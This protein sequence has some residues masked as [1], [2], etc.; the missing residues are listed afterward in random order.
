MGFCDKF[1]TL[2]TF[3]EFAVYHGIVIWAIAT[4]TPS[5]YLGLAASGVALAWLFIAV[6]F[7]AQY[8]D[9]NMVASAKSA[10]GAH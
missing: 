7:L 4:H 3:I 9:A 2:A 8:M 1:V 10:P 5:E 6:A